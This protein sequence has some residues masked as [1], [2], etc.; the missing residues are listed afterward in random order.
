MNF[1][2][3]LI[4]ILGINLALSNNLYA[5]SAPWVGVDLKGMTCQGE[6]MNYGPF[7]YRNAENRKSKLPIVEEYH[8]TPEVQQLVRGN[9]G[10]VVG[11]LS[12]TLGAF[13][14]HY[15]ALT[16]LSYYHVIHQKEIAEDRDW[17]FLPVE[18]YFQRAV[19]FVPDDAIVQML[20]AIYLKKIKRYDL[21]EKHYQKA[22]Q[23]APDNMKLRY[24]YGLFL[25][26]HKKYALANEQAKIVYSNN[27]PKQK[28]K[29][30]LIAAGIWK[31]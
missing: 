15:K 4:F 21:A 10:S 7:D 2:I 5:R 29:K 19:N 27:Y 18:C 31:E 26:K 1:I 28:L 14:N 24:M 8:F 25:V 20:Y 6:I 9:T 3:R 11:D 22:I 23:I 17:P 13:P 12:Y 30:K 16:A